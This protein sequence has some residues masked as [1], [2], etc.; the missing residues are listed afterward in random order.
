MVDIAYIVAVWAAEM[1]TQ[2]NGFMIREELAEAMVDAVALVAIS[3]IVED[4]LDEDDEDI[5]DNNDMMDNDEEIAADLLEEMTF[6][7]TSLI[8]FSFFRLD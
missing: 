1:A 7:P 3:E 4:D 2:P 8:S 5:E 6:C